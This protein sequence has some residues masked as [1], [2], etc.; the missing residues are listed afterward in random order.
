MVVI[1]ACAGRAPHGPA[2]VPAKSQDAA[3]QEWNGLDVHRSTIGATVEGIAAPERLAMAFA[4]VRDGNLVCGDRACVSEDDG[5]ESP[6]VRAELVAKLLESAEPGDIPDDVAQAIAATGDEDMTYFLAPR[7]SGD[8][9]LQFLA[10]AEA[11]GVSY[12]AADA[13]LETA[14]AER[15]DRAVRVYH[16]DAAVHLLDASQSLDALLLVL[17]DPGFAAYAKEEAIAALDDADDDPRVVPALTELATGPDCELASTAE[18]ALEVRG[19]AELR[20]VRPETTDV[21][22]MMRA[23]CILSDHELGSNVDDAAFTTYL[24]DAGVDIDYP[25]GYPDEKDTTPRRTHFGQNATGVWE[26]MPSFGF[27]TCDG[28]RCENG[29][30]HLLFDFAPGKDGNLRLTRIQVVR[31]LD[32][33]AGPPDCPGVHHRVLKGPKVI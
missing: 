28:A 2:T 3:M 7:L 30:D 23:L 4:L 24:G 26:S 9:Q 22:V 32:A 19:H 13:V 25:Q 27:G 29:G 11:A 8:A 6:C 5:L 10:A 1:A 20:P 14:S 17:A 15:I 31:D 12:M 21:A 18:D 16:L 33:E